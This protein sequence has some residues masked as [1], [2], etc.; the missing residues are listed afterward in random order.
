MLPAF[1][2]DRILFR[3]KIIAA[4]RT[5]SERAREDIAADVSEPGTLVLIF[6]RCLLYV[7]IDKYNSSETQIMAEIVFL[8]F[9][10][11]NYDNYLFTSIRCDDP[12]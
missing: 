1:E 10:N 3:S 6:Y 9:G 4:V 12:T 11:Y 7:E 5:R 8:S 2:G